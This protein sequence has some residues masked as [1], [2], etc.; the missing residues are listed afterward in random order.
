M[1]RPDVVNLI[2]MA[3]GE[4]L[5]EREKYPIM[6]DNNEYINSSRITISSVIDHL[7]IASKKLH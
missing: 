3:I 1:I 6:D 2:E 4:L 5:V 7:K